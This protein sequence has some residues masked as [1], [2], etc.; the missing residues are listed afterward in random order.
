MQ[1]LEVSGEEAFVPDNKKN[2]IFPVDD[3]LDCIKYQADILDL[4]SLDEVFNVPNSTK[5][6]GK[7]SE[8]ILLRRSRVQVN[9]KNVTSL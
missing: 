6:Y 8:T 7:P 2:L 1:I 4:K 3:N 9:P 5:V